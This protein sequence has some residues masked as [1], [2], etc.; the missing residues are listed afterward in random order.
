[1][2]PKVNFTLSNIDEVI[3]VIMYFINS[4][5]SINNCESIFLK[6]PLLKDKLSNAKEEDKK[7]IVYNF[8]SKFESKNRKIYEQIRIDFQ[9]EWD[10]INN[11]LMKALEE[12]N[13]I[14]W[15]D[16]H[17]EFTARITSNPICPRY[18]NENIFDIYFGVHN[19]LMIKIVLHELSHFIFFEKCKIIYPNY[20]KEEFESPHLLGS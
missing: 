12:V 1:M 18:L 9:R 10:K 16:K 6:Y 11:P 17:K 8:F 19:D 14:K 5:E 13:E 7:D 15:G 2:I 20:N 3:D 4:K